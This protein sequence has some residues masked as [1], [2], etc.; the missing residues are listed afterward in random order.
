MSMN[1]KGI[2]ASVGVFTAIQPVTS[3]PTRDGINKRPEMR[4]SI[5]APDFTYNIHAVP[6]LRDPDQEKMPYS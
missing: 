6:V 1:N 3:P 2:A 4:R 5:Q